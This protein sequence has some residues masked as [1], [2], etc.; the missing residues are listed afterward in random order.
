MSGGETSESYSVVIFSGGDA[1]LDSA[2]VSAC[3]SMLKDAPSYLAAGEIELVADPVDLTAGILSERSVICLLAWPNAAMDVPAMLTAAHED[4]CSPP[5]IVC[6]TANSPDQAAKL[7]RL[8]AAD[9]IGMPVFPDSL[10][11]AFERAWRELTLRRRLC[12]QQLELER[13]RHRRKVLERDLSS[14]ILDSARVDVSTSLLG[15]IGAV[16]GSI[17][18]ATQTLQS[19]R[20]ELAEPIADVFEIIGEGSAH[21]M[22]ALQGHTDAAGVVAREL[23][24]EAFV[25]LLETLVHLESLQ[26][27]TKGVSL[28]LNISGELPAVMVDPGILAQVVLNLLQNAIEA[29]CARRDRTTPAAPEMVADAV[30]MD[31]RA[32]SL[33]GRVAIEIEVCD[34]GIGFDAEH[35]PL[36]QDSG[37]T[38]RADGTGIGVPWVRSTI[39]RAGG[40]FELRSDGIGHGATA[41]VVLP[42]D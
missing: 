18:A 39:Q 28:S 26:A 15:D 32:G 33:K 42:V 12:A 23:D 4:A 40:I 20:R 27:T 14:C 17:G 1:A 37:Y 5:V 34:N 11:I 2:L 7:Q 6:A 41:T 10:A 22:E 8:G 38:T 19:E 3:Q 30:R 24:A 36:Q 13:E 21:V 29:V 16:V 25:R 31:V 35:N 9:V